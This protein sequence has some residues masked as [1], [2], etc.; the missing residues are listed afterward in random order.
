[1]RVAFLLV[2]AITIVLAIVYRSIVAVIL[3]AVVAALLFAVVRRHARSTS[4]RCRSC[5][6]TFSISAMADF[7]SPHT[8]SAILLRC[9][10]CGGISWCD[11][12]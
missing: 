8:P 6:S 3:L 2:L 5:H 10:A 9:P 12:N 11:V 4:Y 1:M 7:T